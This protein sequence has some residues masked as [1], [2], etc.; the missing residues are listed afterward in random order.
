VRL[1]HLH[2]LGGERRLVHWKTCESKLWECP[3]LVRTAL[4][5]TTKVR[6]I[7]ATPAIFTGGWKPNLAHGPLKDFKL[8]GVSSGRWKAVSGWSLAPPRGPKAIRRMVPAGSVY[9]FTCEKGTAA[10]LADQWLTSVSDD[11]QE[12]RD[13]FGL[14]TW[15]TW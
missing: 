13:G 9:F 1:D 6:L 2:P 14:A 8:V 5:T 11:E 4:E 15:G 10:A 3:P 7:L 12:Q